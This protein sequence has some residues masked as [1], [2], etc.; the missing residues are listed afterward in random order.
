MEINK[1]LYNDRC[2]FSRQSESEQPS[3][4]MMSAS[5]TNKTI[6][7]NM[8]YLS[9]NGNEPN[10]T[11][12]EDR[13]NVVI[14]RN[15]SFE[16]REREKFQ[17]NSQ[18]YESD[19]EC[20]SMPG[21]FSF[22]SSRESPTDSL[23]DRISHDTLPLGSFAGRL[24]IGRLSL[25]SKRSSQSSSIS[26]QDSGRHSWGKLRESVDL[27]D[28]TSCPSLRQ[29]LY[30]NTIS[31]SPEHSMTGHSKLDV[32]GS[33]MEVIADGDNDIPPPLPSRRNERLKP[34]VTVQQPE[35]IVPY[36]VVDLDELQRSLKDIE[37]HYIHD[38]SEQIA[39]NPDVRKESDE[40]ID[41]IEDDIRPALPP[42]KR[43]LYHS[44]SDSYFTVSKDYEVVKP[45]PLPRKSSKLN[46]FG[47]IQNENE[48]NDSKVELDVCEYIF[49]LFVTAC[50]VFSLASVL[51]LSRI[52]Y[53]EYFM[54]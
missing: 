48:Q 38:A 10:F 6:L 26:S 35:M 13:A 51:C 30:E 9:V 31:F 44:R 41:F 11:P 16:S 25:C 54:T 22:S 42:R 8:N 7:E 29:P 40:I 18:N 1:S 5:S 43:P 27:S 36:K 49:L 12:E 28:I 19:Y 20:M 3:I 14:R 46:D 21:R 2:T 52:V 4:K 45:T 34:K 23:N 53:F 37:P 15:S 50:I 47:Q 33:H 17:M 32:P 39:F 24:N